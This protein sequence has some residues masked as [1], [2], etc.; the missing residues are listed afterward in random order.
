[1]RP[2]YIRKITIFKEL[3]DYFAYISKFLS[4]NSKKCFSMWPAIPNFVSRAAR[5]IST[6][7]IDLKKDADTSVEEM[8]AIRDVVF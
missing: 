6:K 5:D 3:L 1:M 7:I 2:K 8:E 4:H